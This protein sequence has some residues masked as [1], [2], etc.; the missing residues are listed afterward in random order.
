MVPFTRFS[1]RP[2]PEDDKLLYSQ[3]RTDSQDTDE[4]DLGFNSV[5]R[6]RRRGWNVWPLILHLGL[7]C[8]YTMVVFL[9][10]DARKDSCA[11][12]NCDRLLYCKVQR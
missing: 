12:S 11:K 2:S 10:L 3:V 1:T 6:E 5:T 7:I 8:V 4:R 9:V